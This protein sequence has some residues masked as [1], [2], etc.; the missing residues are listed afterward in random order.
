MLVAD[1][2]VSL[3]EKLMRWRGCLECSGLKVNLNKSKMMVSDRKQG[4]VAK[5]GKWP[6]SVCGKGVRNA[7]PCAKCHSWVYKRC[8]GV[9]YSLRAVEDVFVCRV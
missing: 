1:S 9:G 2:L 4:F 7:I 3:R 8:S 5:Q 6:C